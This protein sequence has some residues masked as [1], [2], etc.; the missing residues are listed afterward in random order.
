MLLHSVLKYR[1]CVSSWGGVGGWTKDT[2]LGHAVDGGHVGAVRALL[3]HGAPV[4]AL[5]PHGTASLH[6]RRLLGGYLSFSREAALLRHVIS[7]GTDRH[8]S[9]WRRLVGDSYSGDKT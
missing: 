4:D 7:T 2:P 1:D 8:R 6:S 5:A 3:A 9:T